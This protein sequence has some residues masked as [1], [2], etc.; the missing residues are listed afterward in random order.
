MWIVPHS[1]SK[2]LI[3]TIID[4]HYSG[5]TP[6]IGEIPYESAIQAIAED[7]NINIQEVEPLVLMVDPIK[8][9]KSGVKEHGITD[10]DNF[11]LSLKGFDPVS[12]YSPTVLAE[13]EPIS[14]YSEEV[15]P[16][17]VFRESDL[18]DFL[19]AIECDSMDPIDPC[20]DVYLTANQLSMVTEFYKDDIEIYNNIV[21]PNQFVGEL[22]NVPNKVT[23]LQLKKQLY[24]NG[25]L[26]TIEHVVANSPRLTQIEWEDAAVFKRSWESLNAM[27]ELLFTMDPKWDKKYLDELFINAYTL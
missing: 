15:H 8:R 27:Q 13:F 4:T 18:D 22:K 7:S 3:K 12:S 14:N 21:Y 2:P 24:L 23:R 5:F 25:D 17:R 11:F 1:A 19:E 20:D 16:I 9:F 6:P 10:I 26:D